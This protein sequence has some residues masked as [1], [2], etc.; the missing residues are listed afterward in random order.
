MTAVRGERLFLVR[1]AMPAV[2]PGVPAEQWQLAQ[3]SRVAARLIRLHV[4]HPAYYV[5]STEPKAAQTMQEIAGA[6]RV[7]TDPDLTEVHRPHVWL[8]DDEY[9]AAMLAYLSGECPDGWESHDRVIERFDAAVIRHAAAAAE[10][11]RTL[12]IGTH[13]LAPTVWMASRYP[14]D[15]DP[16]RFWAG[17]RFPDILEIDLVGETVSCLAH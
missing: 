9:Q 12:V 4:Q 7:V 16:V 6:Q 8:T 10:H 14:L 3:E 13:G 2:D 15:P 1:H 5:A 17:L 11:G